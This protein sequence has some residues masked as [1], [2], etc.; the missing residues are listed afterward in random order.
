MFKVFKEL[1]QKI[2]REKDYGT[3]R[4]RSDHGKELEN[5]KFDEF[6]TSGGISHDFS[7]PITP[8]YNGVV[9]R[10]NRTIQECSK[11]ILHAKKLPCHFWDEAMNTACYILNRVTIRSGTSATLY[12]LWKGRKPTMK[13]FHVFGSRCYIL[14][15]LQHR[16]KMDPK[17]H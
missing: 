7:S 3:V 12:E 15:D 17:S 9:K 2:Q 8:Q 6:Y 14:E 1:C 10:K 11:V 5:R 16:R 13:Y 4:I